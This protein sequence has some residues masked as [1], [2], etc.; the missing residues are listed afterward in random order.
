MQPLKLG[1]HK[2][3]QVSKALKRR[4]SVDA[5]FAWF[6]ADADANG[7]SAIT[8]FLTGAKRPRDGDGDA[9]GGGGGPAD[10]GAGDVAEEEPEEEEEEEEEEEPQ[11]DPEALLARE[12]AEREAAHAKELEEARDAAC[13]DNTTAPDDSLPYCDVPAGSLAYWA[14]RHHRISVDPEVECTTQFPPNGALGHCF[15]LPE[16][17]EA[18][19]TLLPLMAKPMT[20]DQKKKKKDDSAA[21]DAAVLGATREYVTELVRKSG[22][23]PPVNAIIV[24]PPIVRSSI[25]NKLHVAYLVDTESV[26]EVDMQSI[27]ACTRRFSFTIS[28]DLLCKR[29]ERLLVERQKARVL[30]L[31]EGAA[32]RAGLVELKRRTSA[33]CAAKQRLK[34]CGSGKWL[35]SLRS[36]NHGDY[37]VVAIRLPLAQPADQQVDQRA[38]AS[39]RGFVLYITVENSVKSLFVPIHVID[40]LKR[41][42]LALAPLFNALGDREGERV[43]HGT[44]YMGVENTLAHIGTLTLA[45]SVEKAVNGKDK[46]NCGLVL[47]LPDGTV[48]VVAETVEAQREA[49]AS[50]AEAGSGSE[51]QLKP[52]PLL[53]TEA[54]KRSTRTFKEV[55]PLPSNAQPRVFQVLKVATVKHNGHDRVLLELQEDVQGANAQIVWGGTSL[56]QRVGDLTRDCSIVLLGHQQRATLFTIVPAGDVPLHARV[57]NKKPVGALRVGGAPMQPATIIVRQAENLTVQKKLQPVVLDTDGNL[58]CFTDYRNAPAL[59][60]GDRLD[61]INMAVLPG[62]GP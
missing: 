62:S 44:F 59:T 57:N 25:S 53:V 27:K 35:A 28:R 5:N 41:H 10:G 19:P 6:D 2:Q 12:L 58:W 46:I 13:A 43:R 55:F 23:S 60:A 22:W 20:P 54:T 34:A 49:H 52:L 30:N 39:D 8:E 61:T 29:K 36:L 15:T 38:V 42:E 18:F 56:L 47:T 24:H 3:G 16:S 51:A 14:V 40:G 48:V 32:E 26:L 45:P 11:M 33:A 4:S 37:G 1:K 9:G 7:Q 31:A 50:S 17:H 21:N